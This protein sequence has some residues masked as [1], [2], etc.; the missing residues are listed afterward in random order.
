MNSTKANAKPNVKPKWELAYNFKDLY[1]VKNLSAKFFYELVQKIGK[2]EDLA[3]KYYQNSLS[4]FVPNTSCNVTCKEELQCRLAYAVNDDAL[5]VLDSRMG[6]FTRF[7]T[8]SMVNGFIK[9]MSS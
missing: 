2:S 7:L 6:I 8:C 1:K 3:L 4:P 5:I 9:N